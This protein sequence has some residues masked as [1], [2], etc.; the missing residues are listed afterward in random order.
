MAEV[1]EFLKARGYPD[2]IIERI[3]ASFSTVRE[4]SM[5]P[6]RVLAESCGVDAKIAREIVR[7][8]AEATVSLRPATEVARTP[9]DYL[10]FLVR[11][12]DELLGGGLPR[13]SLVEIYGEPGIGK[14]QTALHLAVNALLPPEEGG[15][16]GRVV[17]VD[18]E[19]GFS[20]DRV[21]AMAR[22]RGLEP[23]FAL[24]RI[25]VAEV[26]TVE[27]LLVALS[28]ARDEVKAGAVLVVVDSLLSPFRQ[29]YSGLGML[30]ARQQRL[31][32][33]LGELGRAADLGA[34]CLITNHVIGRTGGLQRYSP[35]GG[36]VLGHA[37]DPVLLIRR[38][39]RNRR[40]LSVV[41]SSHLPPG[42]A[43]F[44]ITEAG[45]VDVEGLA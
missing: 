9:K 4:L 20:P 30:A 13:G 27:A 10:K 17:Y 41:D 38:S 3:Q 11:S 7:Q 5:V 45:L 21:V 37:P 18:T 14:T 29:E 26:R 43:L 32:A 15:L 8:A 6:P 42:E 22:A 44:A 36:Y 39:V 19:G 33:A 34:V 16:G 40:I 1:R 12:I 31:A 35:A 25:S 24:E 23:E 2:W 28:R